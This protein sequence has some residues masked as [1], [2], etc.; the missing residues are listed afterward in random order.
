MTPNCT[1]LGERG[2]LAHPA[3]DLD[4]RHTDM[5]NVIKYEHLSDFVLIGRS[6]GGM[7]ATGVADRAGD[8]VKQL[9]FVDAFAPDEGR[10]L[11]DLLPESEQNRMRDLA[12]SGNGWRVPPN[13]PPPDTSPEDVA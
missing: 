1:G 12:I 11:L 10:S 2:H 7:V 9:I 4:T 5:L 13:P 3:I 8:K 6:Y